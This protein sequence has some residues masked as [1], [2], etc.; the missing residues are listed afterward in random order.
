MNQVYLTLRKKKRNPV[1]YFQTFAIKIQYSS[2]I[3]QEKYYKQKKNKGNDTS[4][5]SGK[6]VQ[7]RILFWELQRLLILDTCR[8]CV[9]FSDGPIGWLIS[10]TL[11]SASTSSQG[12]IA[13][14]G[15]QVAGSSLRDTFASGTA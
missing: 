7:L 14:A 4:L 12:G 6:K 11:A 3:V 8:E 13:R 9:D 5:V 1:F 10:R 2:Q 15:I